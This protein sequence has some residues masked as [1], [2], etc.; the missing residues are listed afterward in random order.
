VRSLSWC[1]IHMCPCANNPTV[2]TFTHDTAQDT[3]D[4]LDFAPMPTTQ[5]IDVRDLFKVSHTGALSS[6]ALPVLHSCLN[7]Q[8]S[9]YQAFAMVDLVLQDENRR[10]FST[11]MSAQTPA[12]KAIAR[13]LLP[14]A[15]EAADI[16]MV[17]TLFATGISPD[18]AVNYF[19]DTPLI[20]A[21]GTGNVEM[22][23]LLLSY[24]PMGQKSTHR[25]H[26]AIMD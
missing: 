4:I 21:V 12:T 22:T 8:M 18:L 19:Q 7:N 17:K 24:G 1:I 16:G 10:V 23:E 3:Y 6:G 26:Q 15:I 13:T 2:S 5:P 20:I 14:S 9:L 25:Y 11:L